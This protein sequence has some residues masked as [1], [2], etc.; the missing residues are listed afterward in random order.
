MDSLYELINC[1][2]R[3]YSLS[4]GLHPAFSHLV[5]HRIGRIPLLVRW[6]WW[7]VG[8]HRRDGTVRIRLR[9]HQADCTRP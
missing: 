9:T 8:I 5:R 1:F 3:S 7:C 2:V 4:N 6:S